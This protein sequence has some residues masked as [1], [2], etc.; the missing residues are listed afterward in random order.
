MLS[1][2]EV[3]QA[4]LMDEDSD[5]E[6]SPPGITSRPDD[7]TAA[8]P[9]LKTVTWYDWVPHCSQDDDS[10]DSSN[11]DTEKPPPLEARLMVDEEEESPA[12]A[13]SQVEE[14]MEASTADL[15]AAPEEPPTLEPRRFVGPRGATGAAPVFDLT[16]PEAA[17]LAQAMPPTVGDA[18][19]DPPSQEQWQQRQPHYGPELEPEKPSQHTRVILVNTQR[20]PLIKEADRSTQ[21]MANLR[22]YQPDAVMLNDVAINW[23]KLLTEHSWAERTREALPFHRRRFSYNIHDSS[24][25]Q[26]QWGRTG[27]LILDQLKK[28]V[29]PTVEK[30]HF[31]EARRPLPHRRRFV[32]LPHVMPS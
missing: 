17:D 2:D 15:S 7:D 1:R 24:E 32:H 8:P 23:K 9:P 27:L 21:L 14:T 29:P 20:L 16:M 11:S 12:V 13:P 22:L 18:E 4:W 30:H 5:E 10:S 28:P 26:V 19:E 6:D 25:E 3:W 31:A